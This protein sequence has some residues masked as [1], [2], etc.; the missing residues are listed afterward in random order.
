MNSWFD[1]EERFRKI[2]P[3]LQYLR[4]DFQWGDAGEYWR[5][6]GMQSNALNRQFDALAE[7]A[8]QALIKAAKT[9]PELLSVVSKDEET[10]YIWYRYL[11]EQSGEFR[12]GLYGI[13]SDEN[14]NDAGN[15]YAGSISNIAEVSA[16]VCLLLQSKCPLTIEEKPKS[17]INITNS[18]IGILNTGQMKE[19]KSINVNI[20]RLSDYGLKEVAN[21][22]KS[23]TDEVVKSSQLT[24]DVRTS[25]LE[26]LENLSEQA[27]L[28]EDKRSKPG[29]IKAV[30][31]VLG[32]TLTATGSLAEIWSTWGPII[33]KFFGF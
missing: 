5:L 14:G 31:S 6:C 12:L 22:L 33:Q 10:K 8:G 11:K 32:A 29:V 19:I 30:F 9:Y 16:N 18:M 13:Q 1:F 3:L 26:Q 24:D 2:A 20:E 17:D 25:I 21:A 4:I 7:L 27:I 28:T 23:L 15:I